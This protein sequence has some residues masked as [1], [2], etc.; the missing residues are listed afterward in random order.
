MI[1]FKQP[2]TWTC[3]PTVC[4]MIAEKE[5]KDFF[6]FAGHDG[7]GYWEKSKHPEKVTSFYFLE[8]FRY[9]A[10]YDYFPYLGFAGDSK[11]LYLDGILA[12]EF[13]PKKSDSYFIISVKSQRFKDCEH[14][15]LFHKGVIYDPA[16][17]SKEVKNLDDYKII[18]I[19]PVIKIEMKGD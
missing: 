5:I 3:L 14:V 1:D 19:I 6:T 2:N 8:A 16:I 17:K 11:S 9:L 7:S 10:Q 12:I 4:C 15:I 13:E 18:Q